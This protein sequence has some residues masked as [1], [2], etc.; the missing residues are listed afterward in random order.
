MIL[1]VM[2][3]KSDSYS[4]VM[5]RAISEN[6]RCNEKCCMGSSTCLNFIVSLEQ[7][8]SSNIDVNLY[9]H[10]DIL[11]NYMRIVQTR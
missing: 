9:L 3:E 8:I 10:F 1:K 7:I 11:I 5:F 6:I 4:T 2:V